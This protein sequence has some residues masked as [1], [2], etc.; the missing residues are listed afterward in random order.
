MERHSQ[1]T[2][3]LI[4]AAV[5][6]VKEADLS[7]VQPEDPLDLDSIARIALIAELENEFGIEIESETVQPE[8]FESLASLTSL[9]EAQQA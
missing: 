4:R 2:L 8:V 3:E 7:R 1:Q 9:I 6:R 5:A